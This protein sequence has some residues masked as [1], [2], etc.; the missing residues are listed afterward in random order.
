MTI[1]NIDVDTNYGDLVQGTIAEITGFFFEMDPLTKDSVLKI[2]WSVYTTLTDAVAGS[3]AVRLQMQ[4]HVGKPGDPEFPMT[5]I[6][7][8]KLRN[9]LYDQILTDPEYAGGTKHLD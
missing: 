3:T 2:N 7:F 8:D 6:E 4:E 9:W 1:R 5:Q